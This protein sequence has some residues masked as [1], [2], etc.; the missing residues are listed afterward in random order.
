MGNQAFLWSEEIIAAMAEAGGPSIWSRLVASDWPV[1]TLLAYLGGER[2]PDPHPFASH[3]CGPHRRA[4]V[5][6]TASA[7]TNGLPSATLSTQPPAC[8]LDE[9]AL[10]WQLARSL[11]DAPTASLAQEFDSTKERS[12]MFEVFIDRGAKILHV[13][14]TS[15]DRPLLLLAAVE[16]TP[17]GVISL[18]AAAYKALPVMIP[19][20]SMLGLRN[21]VMPKGSTLRPPFDRPIVFPM[22]VFTIP[23]VISDGIRHSLTP[24]CGMAPFIGLVANMVEAV[25]KSGCPGAGG[26]NRRRCRLTVL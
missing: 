22:R 3:P 5:I 19:L 15:S 12:G 13:G 2:W 26:K 10:T 16:T 21:G 18:L 23:E 4:P 9:A 1:S 14:L 7:I 17:P 20:A 11:A 24:V 8:A 25:A 6:D